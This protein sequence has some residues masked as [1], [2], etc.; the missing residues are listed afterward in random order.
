VNPR[1]REGFEKARPPLILLALFGKRATSDPPKS[2][3]QTEIWKTVSVMNIVF[4]SS[5]MQSFLRDAEALSAGE[6]VS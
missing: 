1:K 5:A 4:S 6:R 2:L 3:E